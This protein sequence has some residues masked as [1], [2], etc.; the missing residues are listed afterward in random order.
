MLHQPAWGEFIKAANNDLGAFHFGRKRI[1]MLFRVW[2]CPPT[3]QMKHTQLVLSVR[4]RRITSYHL[5]RIDARRMPSGF[6]LLGR[7]AAHGVFGQ[8]C[9][10][11]AGVDTRVGGHNRAVNHKKTGVIVNLTIQA[12][13]AT[14]V[15][16]TEG[17]ASQDVGRGRGVEQSLADGASRDT[18]NLPGEVA[19]HQVPDVNLARDGAFL[20]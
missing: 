12:N 10:S 20:I 18:V 16:P 13:H 8:C 9:D 3:T 4:G 2:G 17:T 5:L 14:L 1:P 15:V 6:P 7:H 11:Q 19:R